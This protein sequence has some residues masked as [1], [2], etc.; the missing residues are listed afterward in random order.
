MVMKMIMAAIIVCVTVG[1]HARAG[2]KQGNLI[3][4]NNIYCVTL[5]DGSSLG[6]YASVQSPEKPHKVSVRVALFSES[7]DGEGTVIWTSDL[8][9]LDYTPRAD[10][11]YALVKVTESQLFIF[12]TWNGH[13]CTIN[14]H[15]GRVLK[16]GEGDDV[17]KQ[18][19]SVVP[20]KLTIR[21]PS[22]LRLLRGQEL[23]REIKQFLNMT[24][25]LSMIYLSQDIPASKLTKFYVVQF[26]DP[27]SKRNPLFVI[28]WKAKISG[29]LGTGSGRVVIHEHSM[30]SLSNKK[31][32]YALQPDYSLQLLPLT[33]EEV[34]RLFSHIAR[35]EARM[36]RRVA[37]IIERE[38]LETLTRQDPD[39]F[40]KLRAEQDLFPPD[41]HW[42]QKVDPYLKVVEPPK[43]DAG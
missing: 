8:T 41:P 24:R 10:R 9:S 20:L 31:A 14:R 12:S 34:A 43:K 33:E 17:L 2:D 19:D 40:R 22:T 7:E 38:D 18:Y 11:Y 39:W 32:I 23:T 3:A 36:D 4:R 5:S 13:Y 15:T 26:D 6:I 28:V 42:E 30:G 16:S 21:T 35:N 37:S 27:I 25:Q 1:A 29:N